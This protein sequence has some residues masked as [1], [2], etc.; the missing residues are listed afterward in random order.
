MASTCSVGLRLA[1]DAQLV[2]EGPT[3]ERPWLPKLTLGSCF[4][5]GC[6]EISDAISGSLS[7]FKRHDL[8]YFYRGAYMND[9][10]DQACGQGADRPVF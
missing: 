8:R 9:M 7:S 4:A 1:N 2:E 6:D 5:N 3:M 10:Y